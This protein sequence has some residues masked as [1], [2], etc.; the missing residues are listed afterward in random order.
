MLWNAGRE[1]EDG[2]RM[3]MKGGDSR[4]RRHEWVADENR[5]IGF[6]N[7]TVVKYLGDWKWFSL[8]RWGAAEFYQLDW[9]GELRQIGRR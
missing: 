4:Q 2:V 9:L 8:F 6:R 7:K 1:Y 3:P 5:N